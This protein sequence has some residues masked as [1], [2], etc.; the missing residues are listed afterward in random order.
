VASS[1]EAAACARERANEQLAAARD[2]IA[3]QGERARHERATIIAGLKKMREQN[4]LARLIMD[5]VEREARDDA[6]AAG[7]GP[8]Q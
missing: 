2:V 6:G 1:I 5:T 3:V 7:G 4:N 8:H